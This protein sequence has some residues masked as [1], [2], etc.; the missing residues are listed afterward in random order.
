MNIDLKKHIIP[1][2]IIV[3]LIWLRKSYEEFIGAFV[4]L[5]IGSGF[6]FAG[7][8]IRNSNRRIQS[9]GTKTKAKIVKFVKERSKDND[10]YSQIH[11]FPIVRFKDQNGIETTQKLD[12]SANPKR[13]NELMDIIYL[14]K[15]NEYEI[16]INSNWWKTYFPLILLIGGF[17]FSGIGIIWLI[18]KI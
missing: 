4:F 18:N 11:H 14:K 1:F 6:L 2:G 16:L 3:L 15:E 7:F 13:I 8:Y 9:N 5:I 17:L 10:G 12:T